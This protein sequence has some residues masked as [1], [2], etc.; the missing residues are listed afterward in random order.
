MGDRLHA[1]FESVAGGRSLFAE[2]EIK[3]ADACVKFL[4]DTFYKG[5]M[6]DIEVEKQFANN[7]Y[8]GTIDVVVPPK[9]KFNGATVDWKTTSKKKPIA[10]SY[11][12]QAIA[13]GHHMGFNEAYIVQYDHTVGEIVQVVYMEPI[14]FERLTPLVYDIF[15]LEK[16]LRSLNQ[17]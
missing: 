4:E 2:Q 9:Q 14:D 17:E 10:N 5:V 6:E 16:R 11:K 7:M 12:L 15:T 1:A 3:F 13:Y 8:G